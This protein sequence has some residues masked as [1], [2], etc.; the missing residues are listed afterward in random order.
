MPTRVAPPVVVCP[1][2]SCRSTRTRVYRNVHLSDA[3]TERHRQC[4]A[5]G[6]EWVTTAPT[7]VEE[8][9][10]NKPSLRKVA[11]EKISA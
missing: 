10:R 4:Q 2:I 8:F 9:L 1:R 5:C 7:V 3:T 6:R 11:T